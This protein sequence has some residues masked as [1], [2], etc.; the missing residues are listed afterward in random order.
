M[1]LKIAAATAI[2]SI[3]SAED[4]SPNHVIPNALDSKVKLF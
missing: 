2:A 4:L 3:V 1:E